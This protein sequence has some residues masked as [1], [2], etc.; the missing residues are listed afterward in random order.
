MEGLLLQRIN[1]G[2]HL[3]LLLSQN[4]SAIPQLKLLNST[5]LHAMSCRFER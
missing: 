4:S 1:G 5:S 3:I 2:M